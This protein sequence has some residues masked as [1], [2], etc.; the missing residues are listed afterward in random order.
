M[1]WLKKVINEGCIV[2][3]FYGVAY[4]EF[5]M[6]QGSACVVCYPLGV[7]LMVRFAR[8]FWHWYLW[9]IDDGT[10]RPTKYDQLEWANSVIEH[11]RS[12]LKE[13][14]NIALYQ[15]KERFPNA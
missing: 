2:P 1:R 10:R 9:N 13:A 3:T 15:I 5:R 14:E 7:H 12:E 11:L 4:D 6:S 8:R